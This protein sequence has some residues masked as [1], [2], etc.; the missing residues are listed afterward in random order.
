MNKLVFA[1]FARLRKDL[2]FWVC[3]LFMMAL[4]VYIPVTNYIDSIQYNYQY[5]GSLVFNYSPIVCFTTAVLISLYLGVDYSDG[6][7]RNKMM[8]GRTR[9]EIYLA[10]WIMSMTATLLCILAFAVPCTAL[11]LCF[12]GLFQGTATAWVMTALISILVAV[13]MSSVYVMVSM[14]FQ[15][16]AVSAVICL[17]IVIA[18]FVLG[19]LIGGALSEPPT[20]ENYMMIVDGEMVIG[21]DT[22]NPH[23][24][25][26]FKR[27]VYE[28]FD[29]FL[30]VSQAVQCA[31]M[32]VGNPLR[33]TLCA[34][35]ITLA[36]TLGGLG[37]FSRK[38]LK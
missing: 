24:L 12:H 2:A 1:G 16:K 29:D 19:M 33:V 37:L 5:T 20:Y 28:F 36:S 31:S 6:T 30:P 22:P 25:T 11:T 4:G 14:L 18:V 26:G 27:D 38:D 32:A 3:L 15:N 23:Y 17:V 9:N 7:I 21:D 10:N 8:V 13:G 35:G 34:L